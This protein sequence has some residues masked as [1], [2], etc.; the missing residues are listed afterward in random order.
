LKAPTGWTKKKT[1]VKLGCWAKLNPISANMENEFMKRG[2]L[3]PEGCKDL[4]NVLHPKQQ[5]RPTVHPLPEYL[6]DLMYVLNSV[7]QSQLPVDPSA[8]APTSKVIGFSSWPKEMPP[9][10]GEIIIPTET[11]GYKLANLLGFHPVA[12]FLDLIELGVITKPINR[13]AATLFAEPLD[14]EIIS[15]IARRY[16]FIAKKSD[17]E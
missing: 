4:V 17:T 6:K 14:F 16:G 2:Y 13:S 9:V 3:L 7:F 10:E 15:K 8:P 1:G 11:S 12:V 5:I